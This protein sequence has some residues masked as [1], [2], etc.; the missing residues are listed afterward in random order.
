[1]SEARR[2]GSEERRSD[3]LVAR[4]SILER[5]FPKPQ[6]SGESRFSLIG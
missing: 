2:F 4:Y 6:E 3:I 5:G 1:M